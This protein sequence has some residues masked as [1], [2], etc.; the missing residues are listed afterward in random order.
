MAETKYGKYIITEPKR[1]VKLPEYRRDS[2]ETLAGIS[3]PV[4]YLDDE[5]IGGGCYV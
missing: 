5:V 4:A 2:E 1:H 3:T